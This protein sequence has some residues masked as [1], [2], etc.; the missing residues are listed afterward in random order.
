MTKVDLRQ[1]SLPLYHPQQQPLQE[2]S[3][4]GTFVTLAVPKRSSS[5]RFPMVVSIVLRSAMAMAC[6]A[7]GSLVLPLPHI[8]NPATPAV[9]DAAACTGDMMSSPLCLFQASKA[10]SWFAPPRNLHA[11]IP[12]DKPIP[13]NRWWGNLISAA[14][15]DTV[16][17][18]RVW[19]NPYAIVLLTQGIAISFPFDTR[20]FQGAS[21][22]TNGAKS[23][24]HAYTKDITLGG[25]NSK[26]PFVVTGWDDLGVT[27]RQD[28]GDNK[29]IETTL[30]S[31][32]AFTT[33]S[34]SNVAPR[35]TTTHNIMSMNHVHRTAGRTTKGETIRGVK[36]LIGLDNGQ[37][38]VVYASRPVT[39]KVDGRTLESPDAFTGDIRVALVRKPDDITSLD[40]YRG[41]VVRGGNLT[42]DRFH[43]R[44]DWATSGDCAPGLLHFGLQ[45]HTDTLDATTAAPLTGMTQLGSATRG[46]MIPIAT[47]SKTLRWTFTENLVPVELYPRQRPTPER[48]K[49][50]R[51]LDHL[52]ADIDA[53]WNMPNDGSYYFN[54]KKA[55]KYASLCLMA[56]DRAVVGTDLR[57]LKRCQPKL[58]AVL[59]PFIKNSFAHR[60]VYDT[61]YKGI[62]TSQGF[63]DAD[64]YADFGNTIYNDHHYHF[65]YWVAAAAIANV[66][67]PQMPGLATLNQRISFLIR[68][69]ANADAHDTSFPA[70]RM[71]D[72]F[73]GH[74]YSHGVTA[75]VDGKDLESTSEDVNFYYA[76]ALF[77]E[78]TGDVPLAH[79]GRLMLSV[80][81]HSVQT[82]FLM[83]SAN[84]VHPPSIVVNHVPGIYFDNKVSYT[85]WFSDARQSIHM[86]QMLPVT[87]VTEFVRT[88][89]F[90]QEEWTDILTH[91]PIVKNDNWNDPALSL[92]YLNYA[93]VDPDLAMKKLQYMALDDGL[94][95]S[96]ALY[97]AAS[98]Y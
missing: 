57:L 13:T 17:E 26:S 30:V 78:A 33:A 45:H 12:A 53:T 60:L 50:A 79:L 54:G 92:L 22:N 28:Q 18:K 2:S 6:L 83:D 51:L 1:Q 52:A 64:T 20:Y 8:F 42:H 55:Q 14:R 32:M 70:F 56:S 23:Y 19:T 80:N 27:A 61:V 29:W 96:W 36:F 71:F 7:L 63:D 47:T 86:I 39:F 40:N 4:H 82:Y 67:H 85:T 24:S 89:R 68:D 66:V 21:G 3:G 41:C 65:G 91:L 46:F 72:W 49:T 75:A 88:K 5:S 34:Y 94:S 25:G 15:D 31:G 35:V 48:L 97:M 93:A 43:Y 77:G 44:F 58:A 11:S 74:S 87:P 90:V 84:K 81:V 9:Q 37:T 16:P 62:V 38:W 76:M 95:R 10:Q 73:K 69:V 98:R 59:A